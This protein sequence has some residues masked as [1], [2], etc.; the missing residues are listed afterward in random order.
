HGMIL[1]AGVGAAVLIRVAPGRVSK[2]LV[3]VLVIAA[4]GHLAWQAHRASFVAFEDPENPYVYSH[5]TNDVFRLCERV[6]EIARLHAKETARI[7]R[8]RGEAI[9]ESDG[10]DMH[11]Q[12]VMPDAD[13]WP[14]PWYLRHFTKIGW[15]ADMPQGPAAPLII[16]QP[17]MQ[18]LLVEYIYEKQP[19]GRRYTYMPFPREENEPQWQLRPNVPLEM[20]MR[21]ELRNQ[22]V[23]A[24]EES[25][26]KP[27]QSESPDN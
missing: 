14:L 8:L 13:H 22:Y 3:V 6:E 15:Y 27:A 1:L 12:V 2:G 18:E 26:G 19:P 25:A 21:L 10:H 20:Y 5:T 17:E 7:A 4:V 23:A 24:Q 9:P 16:T 11:I